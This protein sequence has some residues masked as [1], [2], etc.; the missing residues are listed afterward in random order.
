LSRLDPQRLTDL[1][2]GLASFSDEI[3]SLPGIDDPNNLNSLACQFIDSIHRV[4]YVRT[5]ASRSVSPLRADPNSNLFDPFKAAIYYRNQGNLEEACWL[6]FL[7]THFGKHG[8][9][10]WKLLRNIYGALGD[11]IWTWEDVSPSPEALGDWISANYLELIEPGVK[12]SFGN[13]RKYESIKPGS[14]AS[15]GAVIASYATWVN[16]HGGHL[17]LF[18]RALDE[19][20]G[21]PRLAFRYLYNGM[22]GV[23]RFGR[24]GKFDFLTMIAKLGLANL[25]ADSAYLSDNATGPLRGSK[26]LFGGAIS[27]NLSAETLEGH[28]K[29][30]ADH[31]NVGMQEMEDALC[32]WQKS[33]SKFK[34]FSG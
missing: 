18:Q 29:R 21:D 23:K 16:S 20:S 17:A 6:V 14:S 31:L 27:S 19:S 1:E 2:N 8:R 7:A 33:P 24:T 9:S 10:G 34:R 28:L 32:N 30:L 4:E 5:I 22:S 3:L 13:H 15:T 11:A 26:L 25:E 12:A